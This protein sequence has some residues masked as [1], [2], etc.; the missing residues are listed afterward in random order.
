ME[1]IS[2][3]RIIDP[4]ELLSLEGDAGYTLISRATM[5]RY[6]GLIWEA[7]AIFDNKVIVSVGCRWKVKT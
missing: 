5:G 1:S 2:N 6:N 4:S 3:V 7:R